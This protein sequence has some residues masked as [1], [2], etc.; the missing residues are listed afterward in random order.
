MLHEIVNARVTRTYRGDKQDT[1][2]VVVT[3]IK[4][5]GAK[6]SFSICPQTYY[7]NGKW[8]NERKP[9]IPFCEKLTKT[10]MPLLMWPSRT[11]SS[12]HPWAKILY[13]VFSYLIFFQ[14][15]GPFLWGHFRGLFKELLKSRIRL[16]G[17]RTTYSKI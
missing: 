17:E 3:L 5:S 8:S 9:L 13:L 6:M 15:G 14:E 7:K 4:K 10:T 2:E 1:D 12:P 16:W 11:T